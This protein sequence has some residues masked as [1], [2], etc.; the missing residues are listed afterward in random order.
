MSYTLV[1]LRHYTSSAL[2]VGKSQELVKH[3]VSGRVRNHAE[4][5]IQTLVDQLIREGALQESDGQMSYRL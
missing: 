3:L 5:L 2:P 4:T 1:Y